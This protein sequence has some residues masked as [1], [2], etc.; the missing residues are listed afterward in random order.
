MLHPACVV[1]MTCIMSIESIENCLPHSLLIRVPSWI[2]VSFQLKH[3]CD[4]QSP[5]S[6]IKTNIST[7][8]STGMISFLVVEQI[9]T[10]GN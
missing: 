10:Q 6:V 2:K 8:Q 3:H 5:M 4:C 1:T 7:Q 9:L